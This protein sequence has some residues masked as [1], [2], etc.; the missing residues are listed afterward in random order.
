MKA[1][2]KQAGLLEDESALGHLGHVVARRVRHELV[3][4]QRCEAA[5]LWLQP[6][7]LGRMATCARGGSLPPPDTAA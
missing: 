6:P 3:K 1:G 5:A 7:I 4:M 2:L